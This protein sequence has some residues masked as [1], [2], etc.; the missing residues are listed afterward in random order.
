MY[1]RKYMVIYINYKCIMKLFNIHRICTNIHVLTQEYNSKRE[2][3]KS[4]GKL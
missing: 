2:M 1:N 4:S 3:G